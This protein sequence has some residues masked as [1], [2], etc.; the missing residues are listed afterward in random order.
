MA[1]LKKF[2]SN[3]V[4]K[5]T[6]GVFSEY[7]VREMGMKFKS[8]TEYK[9]A[10]CVGTSEEEMEAKVITKSCRGSVVKKT[11]KGTGNGT[12]SLSLHMPYE[13]Y[14]QAYGM[15]LDSLIEGVHAY[16]S[17]S[18]HESFAITQHVFDEDGVEMFKAYPNCIIESGKAAK[19]EN[20]AEE[21]AEIELELSV[22]PDE[23]GNGVYQ[24]LATELA[25]S[26]AKTKWMTDFEPSMVQ[27]ASA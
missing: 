12:L 20:G 19:T 13:L 5:M 9:S 1:E 23:Y 18:V 6:N 16:G 7:E 4:I 25:D 10:N 11:V 15:N 3:G 22:M 2:F 14:I 24:A 21:V 26:N 17:N 27:T 8:G